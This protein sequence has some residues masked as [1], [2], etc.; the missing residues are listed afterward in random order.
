MIK[1]LVPEVSGGRERQEGSTTWVP[2]KTYVLSNYCIY[3]VGGFIDLDSS[4]VVTRDRTHAL[5]SIV[6]TNTITINAYGRTRVL[7]N[8]Q[9]VAKGSCQREI[10]KGI[11]VENLYG[12]IALSM[13]GDADECVLTVM[14]GK[15]IVSLSKLIVVSGE[16]AQQII[17]SE[18]ATD[19]KGF[20]DIGTSDFW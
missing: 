8:G 1:V 4:A 16:E 18:V 15:Q 6:D 2:A 3:P 17:E 9:S 5:D 12:R 11:Y 14:R 10:G 20:G 7:V 19:L 13:A